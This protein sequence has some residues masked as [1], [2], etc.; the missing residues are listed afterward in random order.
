MKTYS[1]LN[2]FSEEMDRKGVNNLPLEFDPE[3]LLPFSD[4]FPGRDKIFRGNLIQD[5]TRLFDCDLQFTFE[6]GNIY[7]HDRRAQGATYI[8]YRLKFYNDQNSFFL[9]VKLILFLNRI[10]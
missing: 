6:S 8:I 9:S 4:L 1:E 3:D 2:E 10:D 5:L 7:V